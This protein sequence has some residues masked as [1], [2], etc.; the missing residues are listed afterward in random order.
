MLWSE[1]EPGAPRWTGT[2]SIR[3]E[4]TWTSTSSVN[5]GLGLSDQWVFGHVCRINQSLPTTNM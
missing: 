1:G 4:V 3:L 2:T 5:E